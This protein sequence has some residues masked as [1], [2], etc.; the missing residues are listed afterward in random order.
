MLARKFTSL[1]SRR[2]PR[3][4]RAKKATRFPSTLPTTIA[5]EGSP[6][7]VFTRISRMSVRP[8]IAY[9]P[10][11]PITPISATGPLALPRAL[12]PFAFFS[13]A[14]RFLLGFPGSY[15][16]NSSLGVGASAPT[17]TRLNNWALAPEET[18][19]PS[20]NPFM[21]QTLPVQV[22]RLDLDFPAVLVQSRRRKVWV[23]PENGDPPFAHQARQPFALGLQRLQRIQI[24]PHD[25]R[26]GDMVTRR[27]QICN[28]RQLLTCAACPEL[29]GAAAHDFHCLHVGVVP[30]DAFHGNAGQNL[31]VPL[32]QLPL[33]SL[34]DG[35]K[36]LRK[37]AGAVSVAGILCVLVFPALHHVSRAAKS[38]H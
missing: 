6:N 5:S 33:P 17:L 29:R 23:M 32:N 38:R 9:S 15:L 20:L 3:P 2:C 37:I 36:I 28:K 21:R 27:Q 13:R 30:G 1:G 14:M 26:Q 25:P 7:G 11:P 8:F 24:V 35:L 16:A 18:P 12:F 31:A 4:C 34:G 22:H 19:F 10:L